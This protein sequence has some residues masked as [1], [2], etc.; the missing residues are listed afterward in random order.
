MKNA[1]KKFIKAQKIVLLIFIPALLLN[2]PMVLKFQNPLADGFGSVAS[3]I[4]TIEYPP[5]GFFDGYL[6]AVL[7]ILAE[8]VGLIFAFAES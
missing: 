5:M 2:I 3:G 6:W 4:A 8:I 1:A 7:F